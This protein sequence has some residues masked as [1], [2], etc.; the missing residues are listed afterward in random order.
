MKCDE[1]G[2]RAYKKSKVMTKSM[3]MKNLMV[4]LVNLPLGVRM[5]VSNI[6]A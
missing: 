1:E 3:W 6:Q 4:G 2:G 5:D